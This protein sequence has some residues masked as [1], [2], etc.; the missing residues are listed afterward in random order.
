VW[1]EFIQQIQKKIQ[2]L[3][4]APAPRVIISEVAKVKGTPFLGDPAANVAEWQDALACVAAEKPAEFGQVDVLVNNAGIQHVA[5]IENF[6]VD[7]WD[8]IIA[9]ESTGSW[10][11]LGVYM[12]ANAAS[13]LTCKH[14]RDASTATA[15]NTGSAATGVMDYFAIGHGFLPPDMLICEA[16]IWLVADVTA[17]DSIV[18]A[19]Y[20]GGVG[21]AA[22]DISMVATPAYYWPLG[23]TL[24][25]TIGS[26]TLTNTGSVAS[27]GD[28]PTLAPTLFAQ[29]AM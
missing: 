28:N 15:V 2:P 21:R 11:L 20:N 6:P 25:A 23:S 17:A 13:S 7:K 3:A 14:Y 19:L 5:R 4:G 8:A 22:N 18:T 1:T 16:A 27:S 9:S 24:T 10:Q 26:P 29:A 12:P